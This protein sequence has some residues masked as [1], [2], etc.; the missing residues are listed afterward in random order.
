MKRFSS[1]PAAYFAYSSHRVAAFNNN[2]SSLAALRR[3]AANTSMSS[4]VHQPHLVDVDCNLLHKDLIS[5]MDTS[6]FDIDHV[7]SPLKILHHPSTR[8]IKAMISPS[9]TV[10]ESEKSVHLLQSCTSDERSNI[11][12]KTTVGVHP[13]NTEEEALTRENLQRLRALLGDSNNHAI[14]SCIGETGLD[15]SEG[16]P[17]KKY[18]LPW[19][20]SQLDLAFEF[21]LPVFLHERLAFEDTLKCIDEAAE[22]H[23]G[24][25]SPKII[26]HCYTGTF[27]ECQEYMRRGYY[28]SVSGYILKQGDNSDEVRK[29]LREGIIP[30]ER[31]MIESDA[32]YMG[33]A[34]NKDSFFDAEG[35]AFLGL[36]SKKRKRMKSIYPN[37]PSSLQLVLEATCKEL[38]IGREERGE[39]TISLDELASTTVSA[40]TEF[41]QL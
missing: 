41:F 8:L 4:H 12:I 23:E 34:A 1:L 14:I 16:F 21:A 30:L 27:L 32:P 18:Q 11:S 40:A 6:S 17:D 22:K 5:M 33:F 20:Q 15:Y 39:E 25:G 36:P 26:L 35:D 37:T 29:C 7:Q 3:P 13:Y 38:N 31:L 10:A 28:I 2:L 9:S 24:H 19:F